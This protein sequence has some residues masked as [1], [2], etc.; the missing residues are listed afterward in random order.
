MRR[1]FRADD[2]VV[3]EWKREFVTCGQYAMVDPKFASA[4]FKFKRHL[5]LPTLLVE[6]NLPVA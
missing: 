3:K 1:E 2:I 6:L 5:A 4:I